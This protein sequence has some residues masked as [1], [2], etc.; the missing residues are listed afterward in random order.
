LDLLWTEEGGF[1]LSYELYERMNVQRELF[2]EDPNHSNYTKKCM[3][4]RDGLAW[5]PLSNGRDP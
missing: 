4:F 2:N 3:D 5:S 1:I